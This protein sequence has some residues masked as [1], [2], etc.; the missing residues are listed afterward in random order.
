MIC[1]VFSCRQNPGMLPLFEHHTVST[2]FTENLESNRYGTP[3]MADFDNDGDLDFGMSTAGNEVYWFEFLGNYQ[4]EK[5]TAGQIPTLQLGGGARDIDA[6]GW[7]DMVM[8]GYWFRNSQDPGHTEFIRYRY[9]STIDREIHDLVFSDLN[10]D[11]KEDLVVLGDKEGCFWYDIP[12]DPLTDMIWTKNMI[13]MDVLDTVSDIHGGFFPGGIGDIDGDGAPDIVM[14]NRWYQNDGT[15][16]VWTRKFLPYGS[17][18]Y[19]GLSSRSWVIDMDRDGDNDIVMVG[20]DQKDS[21]AA[22]LE[23]RGETEYFQFIVHLLPFSAPGRRG[24]FH[25]L[26]VADFD[27]DGDADIFTIDQEDSAILPEGGPVRGY[28]WENLDG[29]GRNFAERVVL[30]KNIGGHDVLFGDVDG[31]GDLDAYF[32]VW[33]N[34][35]NNAYGGNPHVDYLENQTVKNDD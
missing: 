12:E 7:Q 25:S 29:K 20:C 13:T 21:R 28:V 31:D 30:D 9:D 11:G 8:G 33:A 18:G 10:G 19:W 26:W 16:L 3:A 27:M 34:D 23:N 14:P 22:W 15:G 24:S 6:D 5:H 1:L 2:D 32:K 17:G 4:W 35:K